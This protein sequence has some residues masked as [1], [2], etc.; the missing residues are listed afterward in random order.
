MWITN[1]LKK[2][3]SIQFSREIFVTPKKIVVKFT[4]VESYSLIF[5]Y[6]L[7]KRY[8]CIVDS[9]I[10]DIKFIYVHISYKNYIK[11]IHIWKNKFKDVHKVKVFNDL[12]SFKS[13]LSQNILSYINEIM[14]N[15]WFLLWFCVLFDQHIISFCL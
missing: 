2:V 12:Y 1:A 4:I 14:L 7:I 11:Y 3:F 6:S 15:T 9:F 10:F 5:I 13:K 8:V